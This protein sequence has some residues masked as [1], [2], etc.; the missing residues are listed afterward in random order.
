M[1]MYTAYIQV[2]RCIHAC[3]EY[4]ALVDIYMY[5]DTWI[6]IYYIYIMYIYT[7]YIERQTDT[8]TETDRQRQTENCVHVNIGL[9]TCMLYTQLYRPMRLHLHIYIAHL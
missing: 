7:L 2:Y 1:H 8:Q 4:N 3:N 5:V 9:Y 6:Y